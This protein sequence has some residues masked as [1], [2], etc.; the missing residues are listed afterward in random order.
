SRRIAMTP[1][2]G[3]TLS[4]LALLTGPTKTS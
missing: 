3:Q 1:T 4:W 2:L